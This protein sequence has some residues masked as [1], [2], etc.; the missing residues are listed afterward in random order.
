[1]A[2]SIFTP[3]ELAELA[4]F[5]AM[6]DGEADWDAEEVAAA[7]RRDTDARWD[8]LDARERKIAE[9]KRA[10]YEAN[11]DKIAEAQRESR[12]TNRARHWTPLRHWRR[13]HGYS[14]TE[15]AEILRVRQPTISNWEN[16]IGTPEDIM[17]RVS[18]AARGTNRRV[19]LRP[20]R[21]GRE[22]V[23]A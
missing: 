16:G 10:Y 8:R 2:R 13:E 20:H 3:E 21:K 7:R 19:G 5:D 23:R 14:Q 15:L 18:A 6:V 9:A 4:A 1:M 11:R 12:A 22:E 17:E